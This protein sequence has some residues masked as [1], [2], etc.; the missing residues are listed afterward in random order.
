MKLGHL[1]VLQFLVKLNVT[2]TCFEM[3]SRCT[4]NVVFK[5]FFVHITF[6]LTTYL[7]WW[8]YFL[9]SKK[10]LVTLSLASC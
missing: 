2:F 1:V 7:G 10:L 4:Q 3:S 8:N 5:S 9:P 6:N